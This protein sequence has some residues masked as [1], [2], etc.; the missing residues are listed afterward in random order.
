MPVCGHVGPPGAL[1][2]SS[3]GD[4]GQTLALVLVTPWVQPRHGCSPDV[5]AAEVRTEEG[6]EGN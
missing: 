5:G 6:D 3:D 2:H 1:C 4:G